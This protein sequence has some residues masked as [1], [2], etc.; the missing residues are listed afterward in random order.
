[1]PYGVS[2]KTSQFT[3]FVESPLDCIQIIIV[4]KPNHNW[5]RSIA[6]PT[7]IK[8]VIHQ[9]EQLFKIQILHRLM[10]ILFMLLS[11]QRP[12]PCEVR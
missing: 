6:I 1:M 2:F 8:Y 4:P 11:R 9:C 3:N 10:G 12:R 7:I 5:F